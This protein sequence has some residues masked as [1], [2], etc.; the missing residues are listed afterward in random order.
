MGTHS[1]ELYGRFMGFVDSSSHGQESRR[2]HDSHQGAH[3]TYVGWGGVFRVWG[4]GFR[5]WDLG[6]RVD[7]GKLAD[8]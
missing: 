5:V 7:A 3:S 1:D 8:P 4:L 2:G 6:F